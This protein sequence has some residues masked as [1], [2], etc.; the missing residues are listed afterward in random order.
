MSVKEYVDSL[1]ENEDVMVFSK[2]YCPYCDDTKSLLNSLKCKYNV[3]ELDE[4][5]NG[6]EIQNY[7][8]TI[9]NQKTVPN[10]FISGKHIGGN[11]KLQAIHRKGELM[12]LIKDF[13]SN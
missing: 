3:I 7:L 11:D 9:T 2:T 5:D 4:I 10:T 13:C 1:I 8:Y 6:R 12:P